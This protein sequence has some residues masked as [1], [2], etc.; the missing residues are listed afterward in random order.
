ME[1]LENSSPSWTRTILVND[2][3]VTWAKAKV[4]V[5][6][7]S[8]HCVVHVKDISGATERWKGQIEDL[9]KCSSY[10]DAVGLDGEAIEFEWN[11]FPEFSSLSLLREIQN[12]LETKNI[13]PEDF[14]DGIIFMSMFNYIDWKKIVENCISNAEK[15]N[16]YA[17]K[18]SPGHWTC[19]TIKKDSGI[20]PPT[21]WYSDSKRV[22]ILSSKVPVLSWNLEAKERQMYHSFRWRIYRYRTLVPNSSLCQSAQCL[23]SSCE[24]VLPIRL[25]RTRRKRTS[26]Y[27]CGQ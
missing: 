7:D 5:Y 11:I 20:A 9:K 23:R 19:P 2:Q 3:A 26:R 4:C 14:K 12:D 17:I 13:K 27:S 8:V 22:V 15:V 6:A 21:R 1:C 18:F 10:Q 25:D 24:L 16:N